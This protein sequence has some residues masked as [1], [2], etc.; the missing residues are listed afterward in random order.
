MMTL[1]Q[2]ESHY[3]PLPNIISDSASWA[4]D[5]GVGIMYET[6]GDEVEYVRGHDPHIVWTYVDSSTGGTCIINGYH[7]VNRIG[8][9]VTREAWT[10][11][12]EI[13]ITVSEGE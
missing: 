10:D 4:G 5:N 9:F 2:W 11:G 7:L 6:Y 3:Q 1:D 13:T 12:D 8:Y